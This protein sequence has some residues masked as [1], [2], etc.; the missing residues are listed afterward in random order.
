[1]SVTYLDYVR[2]EILMSQ[3]NTFCSDTRRYNSLGQRRC[4]EG[5]RTNDAVERNTHQETESKKSMAY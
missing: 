3:N 4:C 2:H 5:D 1:M